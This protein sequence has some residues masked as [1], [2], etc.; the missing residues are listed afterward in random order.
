MKIH[1]DS[2]TISAYLDQLSSKEPVPGGGSAAALTACLGAAL[3]SMVANYSIGRKGNT[4]LVDQKLLKTF[5]TSEQI[6]QRLI[7][8]V[9]L[10]SQ[11]YL[12][13]RASWSKGIEE[14]KKASRFAR[15]VPLEV[16]KLCYKAAELLPFLVDK[17]NPHLISDAQVAGELL[18]A[19]F[20]G[21]MV[22]V[23]VNS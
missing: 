18:M 8:L 19:A 10:D 12:Q 14:Q 5:K 2:K 21:A 9:S 17:G 23:R 4:K 20:H 3:V 6:R 7:V 22:M 13:V 16:C 11:A 15:K 1:F